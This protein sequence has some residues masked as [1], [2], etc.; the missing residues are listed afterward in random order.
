VQVEGVRKHKEAV[1]VRICCVSL[2]LPRAFFG[3]RIPVL[4]KNYCGLNKDAVGFCG[5]VGS[6]NN[7]AKKVDF[8]SIIRLLAEFFLV[9]VIFL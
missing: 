7:L 4:A 9:G 3:Y 1:F 8:G 6:S 5:K 2:N